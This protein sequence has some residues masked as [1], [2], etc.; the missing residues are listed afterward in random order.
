MKN[1][2]IAATLFFCSVVTIFA[3]DTIHF[4]DYPEFERVTVKKVVDG[5]TLVIFSPSCG[6]Q[7]VRLVGVD[8]PE[9]TKRKDLFGQEAKDFVETAVST[10]GG[11]VVLESDGFMYDRYNRRL[12][13]IWI[14]DQTSEKQLNYALIRNGLA[15]AYFDFPFSEG[16]K[17]LFADAQVAAQ[18][19]KLNIWSDAGKEIPCVVRSLNKKVKKNPRGDEK[20]DQILAQIDSNATGG[21]F[22]VSS[23]GRV[24]QQGCRYFGTGEGHY[25]DEIGTDKICGICMPLDAEDEVSIDSIQDT[26][27]WVSSTGKL[28]VQGCQYYG[29]GN[30]HYYIEGEETTGDCAKCGGSGSRIG[31]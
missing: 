31:L 6:E 22:W 28:H 21:R 12:S 13:I 8:A 20:N 29:M 17:K 23:T 10:N 30:G 25:T 14:E 5:D 2:F 24:H 4:K 26:R 1:F 18:K 19:E 7:R 16:N 15:V 27:L 3:E 9:N 11:E